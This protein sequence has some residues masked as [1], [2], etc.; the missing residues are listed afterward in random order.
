MSLHIKDLD[1][2]TSKYNLKL[3]HSGS[4]YLVVNKSKYLDL[5]T[6]STLGTCLIIKSGTKT[7]RPMQITTTSSSSSM[8]T[9]S[10]Y[11]YTGYS[12][13]VSNYTITTG[14][15]GSLS[16]VS[17]SGYSGVTSRGST[18][19]YAGSLSRASTS[20]YAG[21]LSRQSVSGYSGR[22]TGTG[23]HSSQAAG[24]RWT[25]S[26]YQLRLKNPGAS[27][28]SFQYTLY[29]SSTK[30][31]T[32]DATR[33]G[34]WTITFSGTTFQAHT[35]VGSQIGSSTNSTGHI[36]YT[37]AGISARTTSYAWAPYKN[38][39]GFDL[40]NHTGYIKIATKALGAISR[41]M[42][43]Q[44]V[45]YCNP[46]ATYSV[47][48]SNTISGYA[49]GTAVGAMLS[50][51]ALTRVS[52]YWASSGAIGALSSTTALTKV[53]YYW[54]SSGAVGALSSTTALTRASNYN[55]T[56][57]AAGN[58]SSTTALTQVSYY[59]VTS[60]AVGNLSSTTALTASA[61]R[62]SNYLTSATS[63]NSVTTV[64][65]KTSNRSSLYGYTGILTRGSTSGYTG[66]SQR[67]ST[68]GYTGSLSRA[69]T[70]G[71]NGSLSRGSTYGYSGYRSS[72]YTY[73]TSYTGFSKYTQYEKVSVTVYGG[74][75]Y[76]RTG[77]GASGQADLT[78]NAAN[79]TTVAGSASTIVLSNYYYGLS[80]YNSN[81]GKWFFN[82]NGGATSKWFIGTYTISAQSSYGQI[83]N[84]YRTT[85]SSKTTSINVPVYYTA[86]QASYYSSGD[87]NGMNAASA[88]TQV[89]R[90]STTSTAVGALSSTT[91][92]TKVSYYGASSAAVGAL[93]STTALT[94]TSAYNTS[95]TA[96]GAMSSTTALTRTSQYGASSTTIGAL[97]S[98]TALT[99]TS[100]YTWQETITAML[101]SVT[102]LTTSATMSVSSSMTTEA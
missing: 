48:A 45:T 47:S 91:A 82:W 76:S 77:A 70:S 7:Y 21:S 102:T 5:T 81:K 13:R 32:T 57:G 17:T 9:I 54:A 52:H 31:G 84:W 92:R 74:Y 69:S 44:F 19:G 20:G 34:A 39:Q 75:K 43:T 51:T 3:T 11:G 14:Y 12:S 71:Y 78:S 6:K 30:T 18:S 4:P 99:R 26:T 63:T 68:S 42:N 62:Q 15:S 24:S 38:T 1:K 61:T 23:S 93:S 64:S 72:G 98:T 16:R 49:S 59:N 25:N 56:S 97:S 2:I 10:T 65:I 35:A 80:A 87:A 96:V 33:G 101:S 40:T 60:G 41:V 50:T 46:G 86:T 8:P 83:S 90:Y 37:K 58:L 85:Y 55:V 66:V 36:S 29:S 27:S 79:V 88:L 73:A 94:R 22:T 67:N 95:A 28:T 89:S 100:S 53:S